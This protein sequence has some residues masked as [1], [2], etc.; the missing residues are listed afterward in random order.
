[1]KR[2]LRGQSALAEAAA[3]GHELEDSHLQLT[4]SAQL[5]FADYFLADRAREV[6]EEG[7]RLLQ[8]LREIAAERFKNGLVPQQDVLLADVELGRQRERSLNL[9]RIRRVAVA[10]LNTLMHLPPTTP[11]PP[12][13]KQLVVDPSL[14]PA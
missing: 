9:E 13:P 4:E 1:G 3:A 14:P 6:N 5:A 10:R 2:P 11:L 7:V 12:P 8:S